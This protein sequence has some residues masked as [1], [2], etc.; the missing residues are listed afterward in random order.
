MSGTAV[1]AALAVLLAV[2][3]KDPLSGLHDKELT[4]FLTM[5]VFE[6]LFEDG[7]EADVVKKVA[8]DNW[9]L[10]IAKCPLCH[11]VKHAFEMMAAAPGPDLY[12]GR[13]SGL[14]QDILARLRAADLPTRK[15]GLEALVK[16]YVDRRFERMKMSDVDQARL[17]RL[18]EE[19]RKRGMTYKS[20]PAGDFCPSCD[21]AAKPVK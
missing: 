5:A 17:R 1:V 4:R 20:L 15:K 14:P 8:A 6:G 7:A 21:G 2:Q 16:R 18:M 11:P 13:G 12:D 10:F 19:G 9:E 3:Q